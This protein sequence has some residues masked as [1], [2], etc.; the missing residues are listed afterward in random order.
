MITDLDN[1]RIT[2]IDFELDDRDTSKPTRITKDISH[3]LPDGSYLVMKTENIKKFF[4]IELEFEKAKKFPPFASLHEG[5]AVL[6]EEVEE[7]WHE[8]KHLKYNIS[9]TEL[10]SLLNIEHELIQIA[11]MAVKNLQLVDRMKA[12]I[13]GK[14]L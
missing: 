9:E 11:A 8:V 2:R 7:F 1:A 5:Y 3:L 10:D 13:H 14:I 4:E 12:K 6:K